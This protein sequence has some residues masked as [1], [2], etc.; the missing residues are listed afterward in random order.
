[1][2][3]VILAGQVV[4]WTLTISH[5]ARYPRLIVAP[6]TGLRV[7]SPLGYDRMRLLNFILR[8]QRWILKHLDQTAAQPAAPEASAPLPA[9]LTVLDT[10][11]ALHV[12]VAP[13]TRPQVIREGSTLAVTAA[14]LP[15]ARAATEG[16]LRE[17]ARGAIRPCVEA[18]ARM[19]GVTYGRIAIRDQRTRW[20]SCSHAGNLNFNWRLA[21]APFAVL[22]YVVVH[23]LAHRIELNHSA[24]FWQIVV[25][26]C[27][28]HETLR[29]WLRAH[30]AE[31]YF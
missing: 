8:R 29:A 22:D 20:G 21:L 31:L 30:G 5:R 28:E 16:W 3:Q 18:R 27:P 13:G 4:P 24:R 9:A 7:V 11:Y 25:R 23:E 10:G 1:V 6:G 19:M 2:E 14:D 17:I 12:T 15:A 26:H